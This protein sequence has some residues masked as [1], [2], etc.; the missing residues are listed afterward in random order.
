MENEKIELT[1][2]SEL[3]EF[4]LID[5]LTKDIK[6]HNKSTIK[7]IGDDAAVIDHKSEQTLISTDILIEGVHFDMTFISVEAVEE[8]FSGIK[9][10]CNH[11]KV[12]LVG[13]DT[14]ASKSGLFISITVIGK[15]KKDDIVY[16]NGAKANDLLCV[17]GTLGAAY[18]GLLI[19]ER[20]KA[21][22]MAD[23]N[24][25]PELYGYDYIL[26]R[27]LK[28]EAR[29][30][31]VARLKELE[32][33]PTSMIDISD[34]L[35][36]EILHICKDSNVGCRIFEDRIPMHQKTIDVAKEFDIVP[37]VAALNGGEDYELLFTVKQEDYDKVKDMEDV[38]IIGFMTPDVK[39]AE[40]I[41]TDE[42]VIPI[43][44]QGFKHF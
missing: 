16:R 28:P 8:I 21:A 41:T 14:T 26:E 38:R 39:V 6:I 32:I 36:S 15:A 17:S 7:G 34:G 22:F 27:Q 33:K 19:L 11:Y 12:D 44:A 13:G 23:P 31:I 35:A 37:C 4:G 40:L 9:L 3:G 43:E 29:K 1:E 10:A 18:T 30:D 20:E 5:K 2:L 42:H 24:V 25:Q